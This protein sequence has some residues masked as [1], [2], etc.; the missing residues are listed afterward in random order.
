MVFYS[1]ATPA[2]ADKIASA[3]GQIGPEK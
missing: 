3:I 2:D 1:P